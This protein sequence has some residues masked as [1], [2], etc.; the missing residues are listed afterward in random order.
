MRS[1]ALRRK[2]PQ[3]P[4]PPPPPRENWERLIESSNVKKKNPQTDKKEQ[5]E[6][7]IGLQTK[8]PTYFL[9]N[10]KIYDTQYLLYVVYSI[11]L[12]ISLYL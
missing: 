10:S 12:W 11:I 5:T 4:S 1:P 9:S 3:P 2:H 8:N 7:K 6:K